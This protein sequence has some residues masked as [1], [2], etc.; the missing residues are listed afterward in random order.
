MVVND[1]SNVSVIIPT[2]DRP[3][4]L[5][6]L[7]HSILETSD[8]FYELLVIDSSSTEEYAFANESNTKRFGGKYVF[9]DE[10]GL[11]KARNRGIKESSGDIVVFA[12]DDFVA[13]K[14]WINNLLLNFNEKQISCVTGRMI[15]YRMDYESDLYEKAISF[16]RG[17][18]RRVFSRD[19]LRVRGL[20]STLTLIGKKK[21]LEKTPAPWSIGYGYCA[22]RKRVFDDVGL[23]DHCLGRGTSATG[24]DD[25][26]MF[27]RLLRG[28]HK[29]VYEPC[30]II[31]HDHRKGLLQIYYDALNAGKSVRSFLSKYLAKDSYI[32][33]LF[34]GY[35]LMLVFSGLRSRIANDAEL[36]RMIRMEL[37]GFL[38]GSRGLRREDS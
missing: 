15:S 7:L 23:F 33:F 2:R 4:E 10:K 9:F 24:A 12:D 5:K 27:Y 3:N 14:G 13:T 38:L 18:T 17:P 30:A 20:F 36:S 6:N 21:L 37:K 1:L 26:D 35:P 19:D 29:I 16:D 11:S 28:G 25:I 34:A 31:L 22:F 32:K 8:S